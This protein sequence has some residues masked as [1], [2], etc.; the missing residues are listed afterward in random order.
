MVIS[1]LLSFPI[2]HM[3][4]VHMHGTA[5]VHMHIHSI[6]H[7]YVCMWMRVCTICM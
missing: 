1:V 4:K 6:I 2:S 3:K 7:T 5:L